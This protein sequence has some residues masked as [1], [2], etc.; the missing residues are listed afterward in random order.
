MTISARSTFRV[1]RLLC[2]VL[3]TLCAFP[4]FASGFQNDASA[5][6]T[7]APRILAPITSAHRF[8]LPGTLSPHARPFA[9]VG[10]L[11][12][13]TP[14]SAITLVFSRTAAQ[15]SALDALI[16]AQQDPTSPEYHHFLTTEQFGEQFGV[17]DSDI[18]ATTAWLQQ[19]GFTVTGVS[20]SHD[21]I[22][23]S[24]TASQ[25]NAAFATELHNYT[26]TLGTHFAPSTALS[27]PSALAST[28]LTIANLNSFRPRPR[29]I[30]A[31]TIPAV[32]R[33]NYTS[34]ISGNIF[35]GPKDVSTIYTVNATYSAGYNGAGQSIAV[36][37]QTA[38]VPSDI[39]AF[40]TGFGY[41]AK[42]PIQILVPNTGASV[43]YN[44]DEAET[45]LDL[46]Y[47]GAMAPGATIYLVY[48]GSNSNSGVF[49]AVQHAVQNL[50]APIISISYGICEP[51][52]SSSN[53][54]QLNSVFQQGVAQGQTITVA[55]GDTGSTDCY[56]DTT[57]T[58]TVRQSLAVDFPA[59]SQYVT[60]LGGTAIAKANL[61]S[62]YFT[63]STNGTDVI[64][65]AKSYV[66]EQVWNDDAYAISQGATAA[67]ALSA[68]GGGISIYTPRP[69][70]QAGVPGIITG[71]TRLVPDLSLL[72]S[73]YFPGFIYCTSD[74]SAWSSS[75]TSSCSTGLRDA[76]TSGFTLA[77][78]TSFAAPIFAGLVAVLN[79]AKGY[80]SAGQGLINPTL[81]TLASNPAAYA[82]A[83]HDI[84][85]GGNQCLAGPT[86]CS[87]AGAG[88]YAATTGYDLASG[89]GSIDFTNLVAAW[90]TS[91]TAALIASTTTLSPAT[92]TPGISVADVIT[93]T[94][95]SVT[96]STIPT[97]S[98]TI[99]VNG[100]ATTPIALTNGTATYNFSQ[101]TAGSYTVKAAY[102]GD[103]THAAST[104]TISISVGATTVGSIALT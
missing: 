19:Q 38:I 28:V 20:R 49:D 22:E 44:G 36:V 60:G 11:P 72:S 39:T 77:G 6:H 24:G 55:S 74:T 70:W 25:V 57:A 80:N 8:Q 42:A 34:G 32:L 46:E 92:F 59:S 4:A 98:I 79:Q 83:F 40:Q 78:G 85:V 76:V 31:P 71:N 82:S 94:V 14:L 23:F 3:L 16:L 45:D 73:N 48:T 68:S 37:G 52:L 10:L 104:G 51:D 63:P 90:P 81:Y 56:P 86:Y 87:T 65:S 95:A 103:T 30:S 53:Y 41:P 21:R 12:P 15:Q 99:T 93:I 13:E 102:S 100:T 9:D 1:A 43:I 17:A 97:G 50:I 75:Q 5:R 66:P 26:G 62:T 29:I 69:T 2:A 84:T 88:S 89:L 58:T 54:T 96:G 61:S 64:S 35:L 27:V 18:A 67:T 7:L 101:A 47:S 33:P 91:A